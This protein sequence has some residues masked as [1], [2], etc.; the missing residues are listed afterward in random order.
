[1]RAV[2]GEIENNVQIARETRRRRSAALLGCGVT[3]V[4]GL[5]ATVVSFPL[6]GGMGLAP[7]SI[8]IKV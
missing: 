8:L 2:G 4:L 1:M 7:P 6:P 3:R 5:Q